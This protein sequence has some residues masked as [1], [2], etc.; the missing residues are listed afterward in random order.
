MGGE[1]TVKKVVDIVD[2]YSYDS[3]YAGGYLEGRKDG[4]EIGYYACKRAQKRKAKRLRKQKI[5]QIKQRLYFVRQKISGAAI[6]FITALCVKVLN[7]DA[8]FA[9]LS[10]PIGCYLMFSNRRIFEIRE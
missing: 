5:N 4:Y 2:M 9:L 6:L 10:V 1:N 3:G 7:G 8:T